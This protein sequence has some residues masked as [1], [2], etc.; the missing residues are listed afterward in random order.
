MEFPLFLY[1]KRWIISV[2]TFWEKRYKYLVQ[3]YKAS[4]LSVGKIFARTFFALKDKDNAESWSTL[5]K[6][7]SDLI[8]PD[9]SLRG[10][11]AHLFLHFHSASSVRKLSTH[12]IV[13]AVQDFQ[14][15]LAEASSEEIVE[16]QNAQTIRKFILRETNGIVD[17]RAYLNLLLFLVGASL[18]DEQAFF[19]HFTYHEVGGMKTL[20]SGLHEV[21]KSSEQ[22]VEGLIASVQ[23]FAKLRP[24]TRSVRQDLGG[25]MEL[26]NHGPE[27]LWATIFRKTAAEVS[28]FTS[29][30]SLEK[31]F[32][33]Y[34]LSSYLG[35]ER[36]VKSYL[37]LQSPGSIREHF[38]FKV[39]YKSGSEQIRKSAGAIINLGNVVSCF[40]SSRMLLPGDE[41]GGLQGDGSQILGP[42]TITLDIAALTSEDTLVPGHVLTVNEHREVISSKLIC[43]RTHLT[44][45]RDADIGSFPVDQYSDD[46]G[47]FTELGSLPATAESLPI[48]DKIWSFILSRLRNADNQN[49]CLSLT[50]RDLDLRAMS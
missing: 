24:S 27:S 26:G 33:C 48:R 13:N 4:I 47:E 19:G 10:D 50:K 34:R 49:V 11:L 40:G 18:E 12:A 14:V 22:T 7:V 16:I 1:R 20:V 43:I 3:T 6:V 5:S 36:I 8:G 35:Q 39:Y 23:T 42:K 31:H 41:F 32:V 44:H 30:P 46:L 15:C 38:A 9:Q 28:A 29:R 21:M 25:M 17:G 37:V 2:Y 45:S